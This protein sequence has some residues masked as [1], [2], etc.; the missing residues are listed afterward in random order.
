MKSRFFCLVI[1]LGYFMLKVSGQTNFDYKKNKDGKIEEISSTSPYWNIKSKGTISPITLPESSTTNTTTKSS[2]TTDRNW[3]LPKAI[4]ATRLSREINEA[5]ANE[6]SNEASNLRAKHYRITTTTTASNLVELK[7]N[8]TE[9][10]RNEAKNS[11]R[12]FRWFTNGQMPEYKVKVTKTVNS[13][14]IYFPGTSI[15]DYEKF[16]QLPV[17]EMKEIIKSMQTNNTNRDAILDGDYNKLILKEKNENISIDERKK[18]NQDKRQINE[19]KKQLEN[20]KTIVTKMEDIL[21][22]KTANEPSE[23]NPN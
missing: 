16:A 9:N 14:D 3:D 11:K 2:G 10:Q 20:D 18:I 22:N 7:K 19:Q 15:V 12:K 17:E 13:F 21:K 6:L 8:Y 23:G 4:E 5:E 1:F